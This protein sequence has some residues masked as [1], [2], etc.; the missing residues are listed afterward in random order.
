MREWTEVRE[1]EIMTGK[2]VS[3]ICNMILK[4]I[5]RNIMLN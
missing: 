2:C 5:K 3:M 1:G 4:I